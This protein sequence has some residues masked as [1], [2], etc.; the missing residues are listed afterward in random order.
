MAKE[1]ITSS[2]MVGNTNIVVYEPKRKRT[3]FD[4]TSKI[5]SMKMIAKRFE[6]QI[7]SHGFTD[8]ELEDIRAYCSFL[9]L[10]CEIQSNAIRIT[11]SGFIGYLKKINDRWMF[12]LDLLQA[13][14]IKKIIIESIKEMKNKKIPSINIFNPVLV[15]KHISMKLNRDGDSVIVNYP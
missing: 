10:W 13:R 14:D 3:S 5:I 4:S 15:S 9:R 1:F 7:D 2:S 12:K 11:K 8:T 6:R